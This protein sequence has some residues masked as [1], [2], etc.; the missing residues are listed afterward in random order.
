M[1]PDMFG[2]GWP[3]GMLGAL[4]LL[5]GCVGSV[6]LALGV[7]RAGSPRPDTL[8]E[9][10]HQYEQGAL[11]RSEFERVKRVI[12]AE[13]DPIVNVRAGRAIVVRPP[14]FPAA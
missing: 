10:W 13:H 7:N 9:A 5:A 8:L 14:R 1:W 2:P 12:A 3:W 6:W 11:L 4:G